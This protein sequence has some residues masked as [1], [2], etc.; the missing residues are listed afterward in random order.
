MAIN[1]DLI[2]TIRVD[3]LPDEALTLDS[4]FPH[5]VGTEL[6]SSTIQELVDLVATTIDAGS[7]V[8]FLAESRVSGQTLP[9][10]PTDP[11]F[12][13][14]GVGTFINV[15]GYPDVITTENLNAL[16]TA[17][18]HWVLGVEIPITAEVGVQTVTGS[19]VDNSDPLNP[20]VNLSSATPDLEAVLT[21]GNVSTLP[22]PLEI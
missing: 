3:Q 6:K 20:V 15:N 16:I 14:V 19:A 9:D 12:M 18:D 17:T 5:T 22:L 10:I 1:P 4:L 8:G 21:E 2:T 7:G 11:S 13:L